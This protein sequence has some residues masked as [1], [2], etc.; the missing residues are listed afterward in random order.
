MDKKISKLTNADLQQSLATAVKN[1]QAKNEELIKFNTEKV[2][3]IEKYEG[4]IKELENE[5]K[6]V[7]SSKEMFSDIKD[8]ESKQKLILMLRAKQYSKNAIMKYIDSN[9]IDDIDRELINYTIDNLKNLPSTLQKYF[10]EEETAFFENLKTNSEGLKNRIDSMLTR[11]LD[12][13][14]DLMDKLVEEKGETQEVLN[15]IA[16]IT[17]SAK[18]MNSMLGNLVEEKKE[19]NTI[20][21]DIQELQNEMDDTS[22]GMANLDANLKVLN[23]ILGSVSLSLDN[24]S[25]AI[26]SRANLAIGGQG[27]GFSLSTL[28]TSSNNNNLEKFFGSKTGEFGKDTAGFIRR[29]QDSINSADAVEARLT[30]IDPTSIKDSTTLSDLL[31]KI[32]DDVKG[33]DPKTATNIIGSGKDLRGTE[34][35]DFIIDKKQNRGGISSAIKTE[36]EKKLEP[37]RKGVELSTKAMQDYAANLQVLNK[38]T[39]D[40][41]QIRNRI[42]QK[43]VDIANASAARQS[44]ITGR[45]A[46]R[47]ISDDQF[48]GGFNQRIG[49]LLGQAG[50][51]AAP[52]SV[53]P[54]QI[55]AKIASDTAGLAGVQAKLNTPGGRTA[56]NVAAAD[57]FTNSI[58]ASQKALEELATATEPLA[59]VERKLAGIVADRSAKEQ[60]NK[61]FGSSGIKDRFE[62]VANIQ[63]LE[64]AAKRGRFVN[65]AEQQRA[66]AGASALGGAGK[67]ASGETADEAVKRIFAGT[68]QGVLKI[69]D[70]SAS[71]DE[72]GLRQKQEELLKKQQDFLTAMLTVNQQVATTLKGEL[73]GF[74]TSADKLT[75]ALNK[76]TPNLT[77]TGTTT[78]DVRIVGADVL[79]TI[80]PSITNLVSRQVNDA[81]NKVI[82]DRFPDAGVP[83]GP[84][85]APPISPP[86]RRA[87]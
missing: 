61:N 74:A 68:E 50:I 72:I 49:G 8:K 21:I 18:V 16:K 12:V 31:F 2:E 33:F 24:Q 76:F 62:T 55:Q 1:L 22:A 67:L 54:E 51:N 71:K 36:E 69:A 37:F 44:A 57:A 46:N 84:T 9:A 41:L 83:T 17:D 45:D 6:K 48:L 43:G 27:A 25:K 82:A 15:V 32:K 29:T 23:D 70:Q 78:V 80:E 26:G 40:N 35:R 73:T 59:N 3:M 53:T 75:D 65:V 86:L 14:E 34:L 79:A 19:N 39:E 11:N 20:N 10:L 52:G 58:R 66:L 38:I 13:L 56:E 30:G 60:L 5:V 28:D 81:V 42:A 63:F 7:K 85:P 87:K 4:R 47:F 64:A 77:L